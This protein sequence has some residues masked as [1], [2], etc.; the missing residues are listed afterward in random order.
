MSRTVVRLTTG[1]A[2]Y[3]AAQTPTHTSKEAT[4]TKGNQRHKNPMS[5]NAVRR[6]DTC[7]ND[8]CKHK[9]VDRKNQVDNMRESEDTC[10]DE[11]KATVSLN[12]LGLLTC[13]RL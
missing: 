2:F 5:G 11:K 1:W 6:L 13:D 3:E 4:T 8:E 9:Q 12:T 10:Y 7:D